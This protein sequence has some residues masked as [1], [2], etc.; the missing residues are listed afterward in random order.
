MPLDV[1]ILRRGQSQTLQ[2]RGPRVPGPFSCACVFGHRPSLPR[3]SSV[4]RGTR[5]QV[6]GPGPFPQVLRASPITAL[7]EETMVGGGVCSL[8]GRPWVGQTV[9]NPVPA[10]TPPFLLVAGGL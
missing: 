6:P 5:P 10:T 4:V 2:A 7:K 9:A 8:P 3:G 1:R